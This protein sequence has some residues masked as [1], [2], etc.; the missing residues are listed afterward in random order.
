MD[1]TT[2]LL[3]SLCRDQKYEAANNIITNYNLNKITAKNI[4]SGH[5]IIHNYLLTKG[6]RLEQIYYINVLSNALEENT[7]MYEA[8]ILSINHNLDRHTLLLDL[9]IEYSQIYQDGMLWFAVPYLF[10]TLLDHNYFDCSNLN[11]CDSLKEM[12]RAYANKIYPGKFTK[13]AIK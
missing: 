7:A 5:K 10:T 12:I 9:D 3:T 4:I 1:D 8:I 6:D 2:I 13:A 11:I